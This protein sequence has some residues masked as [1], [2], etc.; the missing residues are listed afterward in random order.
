MTRLTVVSFFVISMMFV[1]MSNAAI[2]PEDVVGIWL[3]DDGNN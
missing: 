3:F 2:N 1:G